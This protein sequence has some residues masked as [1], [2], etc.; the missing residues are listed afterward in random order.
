[1]QV[2]LERGMGV[3]SLDQLERFKGGYYGRKDG[4]QG[5]KVSLNRI[6]R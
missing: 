6:V 4:E 3:K 2:S 5:L 1:M